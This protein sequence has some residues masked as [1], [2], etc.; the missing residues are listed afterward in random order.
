MNKYRKLVTVLAVLLVF[1]VFLW[2]A[3]P[4]ANSGDNTPAIGG[5]P[6]ATSV[7]SATE[8]SYDFGSISMAKGKVTH[9]FKVKNIGDREVK[10]NKLYTSCMC[11]SASLLTAGGKQGPFGM[12]GHA[13]IPRIDTPLA[14]G[15][16]AEVEV[17][18]DPAAHG[19]A[20][21]GRI[22]RKIM[23]E[24]DGGATLAIAISA[25]VTP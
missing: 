8:G 3:R 23:L 20:G 7:L 13:A 24:N 17:V 18:F 4:V 16:E 2:I 6:T 21:V 15:G 14:S 9:V 5:G 1:G 12:P 11:T 22:E 19:P 10:I 25:T